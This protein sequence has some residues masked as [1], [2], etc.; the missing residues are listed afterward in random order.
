MVDIPT[1]SQLLP[2]G[3]CGPPSSNT[4]HIGMFLKPRAITTHSRTCKD[5]YDQI[6]SPPYGS[7]L[8]PRGSYKYIGIIKMFYILAFLVGIGDIKVVSRVIGKE[9]LVIS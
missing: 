1:H 2:Q 9:R 3:P 8:S 6:M 7:R 4:D 5:N